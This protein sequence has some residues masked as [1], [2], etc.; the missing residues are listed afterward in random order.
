MI[1]PIISAWN[2]IGFRI[3]SGGFRSKVMDPR[4]MDSSDESS[5]TGGEGKFEDSSHSSA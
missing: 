1:L 2:A 4:W 5:S 3:R